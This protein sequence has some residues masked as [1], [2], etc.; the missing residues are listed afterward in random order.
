MSPV[1]IASSPC[2]EFSSAQCHLYKQIGIA[3]LAPCAK[4]TASSIAPLLPPPRITEVNTRQDV[5]ISTGIR[6]QNQ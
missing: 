3:A 2:F 5:L 4:K 1:L 6:S